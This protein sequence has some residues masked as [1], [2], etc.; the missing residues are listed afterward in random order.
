MF[1]FFHVDLELG[2][3]YIIWKVNT[4]NRGLILKNIFCALC[5][6]GWGFHAKPA[7]FNILS[8]DL[9]E[10]VKFKSCLLMCWWR[11]GKLVWPGGKWTA[12]K[13]S[14]CGG[15]MGVG[16][17]YIRCLVI[18]TI[19][20]GLWGEKRLGGGQCFPYWSNGGCPHH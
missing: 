6:W 11:C 18:V 17:N 3:W 8:G 2:Y 16:G 13:R 10:K 20:M 15:E 19:F 14:L 9:L 12:W 1:S 5:L 4:K 7:F